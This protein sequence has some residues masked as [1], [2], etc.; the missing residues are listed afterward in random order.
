M[1][2]TEVPEAGAGATADEDTLAHDAAEEEDAD[3][4]KSAAG[5]GGI[6]EGQE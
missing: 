3:L 4:I 1:S 5:E 2:E 6:A